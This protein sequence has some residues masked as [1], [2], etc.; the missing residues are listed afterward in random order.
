[1]EVKA[2]FYWDVSNKI[3]SYVVINTDVFEILV[4]P[5]RIQVGL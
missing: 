4:E 5:E 2:A 1:M 3:I